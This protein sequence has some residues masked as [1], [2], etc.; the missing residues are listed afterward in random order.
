MDLTN[1][2]ENQDTDGNLLLGSK[3]RDEQLYMSQQITTLKKKGNDASQ[4][5]SSRDFESFD[6]N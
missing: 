5:S 3:R 4:N 2:S 1:V 6:H